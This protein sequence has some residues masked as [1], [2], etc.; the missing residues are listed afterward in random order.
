VL[1]RGK[2]KKKNDKVLRTKEKKA[3][4]NEKGG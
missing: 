4:K 1:K 3:E 2:G